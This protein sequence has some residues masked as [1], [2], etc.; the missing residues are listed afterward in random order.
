MSSKQFIFTIFIFL[1]IGILAIYM[2][3]GFIN[4][5]YN[6]IDFKNKE[7]LLHNNPKVFFAGDSRAERQLN[8]IIASDFSGKGKSYFA[9][10]ANSSAEVVMLSEFTKCNKNKFKDAILIVSVSSFD[11]NDGATRPGY[12]SNTTLSKL[13]PFQNIQINANHPINIINFIKSGTK[14]LIKKK[15]KIQGTTED[16]YKQ[17]LGFNGVNGVLLEKDIGDQVKNCWYENW[18][19]KS[20]RYNLFEKALVELKANCKVL[21]IYTAPYSPAWRKITKN[22]IYYNH[23]L[24]FQYL[25]ESLCKKHGIK[26]INFFDDPRFEN[27]DFYDQAHLNNEGATKFTKIVVEKYILPALKTK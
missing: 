11:L 8:P 18:N 10:I 17:S 23:E 5:T 25:V 21:Y 6:P 3:I 1:F 26:F 14:N 12:I 4:N 9:N 7:Y 2:I 22:T 19:P 13:T 27:K 24:E 15:I 16:S 20:I